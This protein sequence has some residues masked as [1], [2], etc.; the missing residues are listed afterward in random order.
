[1]AILR[2]MSIA[3]LLGIED[4][5]DEIISLAVKPEVMPDAEFLDYK[6]DCRKVILDQFLMPFRLPDGTVIRR[7]VPGIMTSGS[8][9][10][11]LMNSIILLILDTHVKRAMDYKAGQILKDFIV[12]IGGDDNLQ[13]VPKNFDE[14]LYVEKWALF[15][16]EVHD[17][18]SLDS[19]HGA[20]FFSWIFKVEDGQVSWI[21]ARFGKHVESLKNT[22]IENLPQAL[23]SHM[24]NHAHHKD[25]YQFLANTF[26]RGINAHPE[27]FKL[28]RLPLRDSI[29]DH[30][31][32][33]ESL[34]PI[35]L[36][37]LTPEQRIPV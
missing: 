19:M 8:K 27:I 24:W 31:M 29:L 18:Q 14:K 22:K 20:E 5:A 21:P 11:I 34:S 16:F 17:V 33:Y 35:P 12:T 25:N 6:R 28:V 30:F 4:A 32:G 3:S 1:V 15:G 9:L 13:T 26:E 37:L 10:T 7:K 23:V 36:V 2:G